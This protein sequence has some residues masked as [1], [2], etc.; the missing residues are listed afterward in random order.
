MIFFGVGEATF[1]ISASAVEEIRGADGL[2][3]LVQGE[4][5]KV[6]HLLER[7]GKTYYVVDAGCHFRMLPIPG[8]RVLVLRRGKAALLVQRID[9]MREVSSIYALPSAFRG[10]ERQWY[11]GLAAI[12]GAAGAPALGQAGEEFQ[13]VPVLNPDALLT[14]GEADS[15]GMMLRLKGAHA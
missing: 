3:P 4:V 12:P 5:A 10:E 1:A 9:L 2:R 6:R 13:V 11:R 14:T 15:L 7:A 8:N